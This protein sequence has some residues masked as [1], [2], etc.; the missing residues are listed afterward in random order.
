MKRLF[1]DTSYFIAV[2][3][4]NDLAHERAQALANQ[5]SNLVTTAWI[6][7]ELAAYLSAPLNREL[8]NVLLASVRTSS[9][10][11]FIPASQ[12]IF[13]LGCELYAART[14][15]SW[16]LVDC[17]SFVVMQRNGLTDALTTDHHFTQAGFHA[18]LAGAEK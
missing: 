6:M 12:E 10:V 11:E 1:A 15:K 9:T 14:D 2:I 16:S 13:D 4:P 3:A 8:F 7:S 18:I 17:I 5:P